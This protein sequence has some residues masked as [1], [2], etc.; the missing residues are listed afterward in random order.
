[1]GRKFMTR[2]QDFLRNRILIED[3]A[4]TKWGDSSSAANVE[5]NVETLQVFITHKG[6]KKNVMGLT[7]NEAIAYLGKATVYKV[8]KKLERRKQ[9]K[10]KYPAHQAAMAKFIHAADNEA[11][12]NRD[13]KCLELDNLRLPVLTFVN[14]QIED[15]ESSDSDNDDPT[16]YTKDNVTEQE[17]TITQAAQKIGVGVKVIG[18][19]KT[20]KKMT[21]PD[22]CKQGYQ[23]LS[24][25][26]AKCV[27][28]YK[29]AKTAAAK[30]QILD[31]METSLQKIVP[32]VIKKIETLGKKNIIHGDVTG[33][34]ILF[35]ENDKKKIDVKLI[36]YGVSTC[37][38]TKAMGGSKNG[39]KTS[40]EEL[41]DIDTKML[42]KKLDRNMFIAEFKT[43]N[44]SIKQYLKNSFPKKSKSKTILDKTGSILQNIE[45]N[46]E[47]DT[48]LTTYEEEFK[49]RIEPVEYPTIVRK[50]GKDNDFKC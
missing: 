31:S 1:M 2:P 20:T 50:W 33:G 24:K 36:D 13:L 4:P 37:E 8:K 22:M 26:I 27:S 35:M 19:N 39:G 5:T 34:N 48:N 46:H 29:G 10:L 40:V 11:T 42:E 15:G 49:K 16:N 18:Y 43:K 6:N 38:N 47:L 23:S 45:F 14:P 25:Y 17:Y 30:K 41:K 28:E 44:S 7:D 32:E 3:F 12:L 21:M 9:E